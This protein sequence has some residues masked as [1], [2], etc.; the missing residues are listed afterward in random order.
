MTTKNPN[1]SLYLTTP[2]Y[3]VN[4]K[5]H[6]G[7]AYTNI[8]CDTFVR[9]HHWLGENVYFLTGTDEH[10]TKI[11]KT[12]TEHKMEPRQYV[13]E[14]V[15]Q[16]RELWRLLG[17][18]Y[19]YFIRTTDDAHKETVQNVLSKL[20]AAGDI[21]KDSYTGWY[22]TPCESFWTKLQLVEGKCPDCGR[23]VQ[24][25]SEENYFFKLSKYQEWLVGYIEDH[26]DFVLP[27]MRRNEILSFLKEPLEDLCITRPK[28]R[29]SWGIEYPNSPDHVVYVWFD[30][31]INYVSAIGMTT[32]SKK[33]LSYWPADLHIVGKDIL[34][35]HAVYWPIML[36]SMGLEMPK[37]VL[38]HGWWTM[39]GTKVSKSRGNIV[40]PIV[41]AKV[42]GVDA[43]RYFLLREVTVGYDGAYSEDLLR[44]RYT[45]DLANDLGNLFSR[46]AAMLGKYFQ[47]AVPEVPALEKEPLLTQ[48][49]ELWV[50]VKESMG[51]YDPRQAL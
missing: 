43:F 23:E 24:E 37:T 39:Q 34:R 31:L 19:D 40:D 30:A 48:T 4:A 42:Y 51:H 32:D 44:Q 36:K 33:F 2:L 13:D 28:A 17:I 15:P 35:Q 9:Y 29:L 3:Y 18:Q 12:A 6:I 26:N 14:M 21:Y 38:A 7:H 41:L 47:G 45:S 5:P 50:T 49:F 20:E 46:M 22:C 27:E 1:K 8:L 16:F 11:E 25:L 10:G